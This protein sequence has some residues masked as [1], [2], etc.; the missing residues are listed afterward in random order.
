MESFER[1]Q[2][3]ACER[4][5]HLHRR[6]R[7][8]QA[9]RKVCIDSLTEHRGEYP[10]MTKLFRIAGTVVMVSLLLG[11]KPSLAG[12]RSG[13]VSGQFLKIGTSARTLAMGDAEVSS[14]EGTSSI[15]F[16]P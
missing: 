16:N 7:S 5:L 6:I 10:I 2:P 3:R 9:G 11:M 14:A 1:E 4:H 15:A 13:T 8:G 12:N